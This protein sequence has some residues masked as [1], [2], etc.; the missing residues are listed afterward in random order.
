MVHSFEILYQGQPVQVHISHAHLV[1][2]ETSFD[3]T[4]KLPEAMA[5][6]EAETLLN[7][8]HR[9][10]FFDFLRLPQTCPKS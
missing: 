5:E 2:G 1:K 9:E 8:L 10:G 7:Y 4:F 6:G 3:I